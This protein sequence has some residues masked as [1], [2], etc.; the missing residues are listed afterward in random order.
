MRVDLMEKPVRR[1]ATPGSPGTVLERRRCTRKE[2]NK[3]NSFY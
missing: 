2:K 3:F 1:I